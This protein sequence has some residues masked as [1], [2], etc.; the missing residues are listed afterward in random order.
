M[1][2]KTRTAGKCSVLRGTSLK[3]EETDIKGLEKEVIKAYK[4]SVMPDGRR[5]RAV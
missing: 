4:Y 3:V 1:G 2:E 5:R